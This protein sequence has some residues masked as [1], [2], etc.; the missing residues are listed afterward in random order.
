MSLYKRKDTGVWWMSLK[1]AGKRKRISTETK[2]KKRAELIHAQ[3]L[4]EIQDGRWFERRKSETI[5]FRELAEKYVAK[6]KRQRDPTSLNRLL[7]Y[8]GNMMLAEISAEM[9]EDYIL[10]RDESE[11]NPKPATIYQEFSLGRRMYNVARKRWK[12]VTSN[13]FADVEFYELLEVNNSRT[14]WLTKKEEARLIA[15]ATPD[16]LKDV[17]IFALHTGCRRGEI[18]ACNWK[19]HVDMKRR[20]ITIQASKNGN[21]KV[22]PITDILYSMLIR[23]SKVVDISGMVFP[24]SM[25][26]VKDAFVRAAKKAGLED[27]KFHDL[28]HTFATRLAQRGIDLYTVKELMGHKSIRT[29][30]RYAHHCPE[31]LRPAVAVLD[32][33]HDF[34]TVGTQEGEDAVALGSE[35]PVKSGS[36]TIGSV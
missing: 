18:L 31:S 4:G 22:I 30:E 33:C 10:A 15:S 13:P 21:L 19:H 20:L 5:T 34:V 2:N 12:W 27:F 9:V 32:F 3:A 17:I 28:R 35:N 8:F 23:R 14:R 6:Y 1:I 7:P 36:N 25:P 26:A 11:M 16:Y 24:H 29:T